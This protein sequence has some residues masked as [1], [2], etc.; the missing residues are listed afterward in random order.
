MIGKKASVQRRA[1]LRVCLVAMM[2][3]LIT[4]LGS[5][6]AFAADG[7]PISPTSNGSTGTG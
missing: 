6:T 7:G 1:V 3:V 4:L 5:G 2:V